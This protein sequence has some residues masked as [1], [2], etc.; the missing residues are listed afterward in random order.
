MEFNSEINVTDSYVTLT[1]KPVI[2]VIEGG[3]DI[4]PGV[5][6]QADTT[7]VK[8]PSNPN[9]NDFNY[10][11]Q[12]WDDTVAKWIN[13][14]E[15]N[16]D[17]N[18]KS[19]YLVGLNDYDSEIRVAVFGGEYYLDDKAVKSDS[20]KVKAA[21]LNERDFTTDY[22]Q[23]IDV[24]FNPTDFE[25]NKS[26]K[27]IYKN[28]QKLTA[29]KDYTL[30][31]KGIDQVGFVDIFVT[32]LPTAATGWQSGSFEVEDAYELVVVNEANGFVISASDTS[33][34]Y[35][36]KAVAPSV[37]VTNPNGQ[38]LD[39]S[40]Y[41]VYSVGPNAGT[42]PVYAY[43]KGQGMAQNSNNRTHEITQKDINKHESDFNLVIPD[44][45]WDASEKSV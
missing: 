10:Q 26:Y 45:V 13:I 20:V 33:S 32:I 35:N 1:G 43:V 42:Y 30:S 2:K 11:W 17:D 38:V 28:G 34:E 16:D 15:E 29:G 5:K 14:E 31:F 36:G 9:F 44:A 37:K 41:T 4:R 22:N 6:L 21:D 3:A 23:N 39:T 40:E 12:K 27:D 24:P 25:K 8:A 19:T 18:D 7:D